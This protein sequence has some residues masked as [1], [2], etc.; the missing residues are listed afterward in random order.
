MIRFIETKKELA[1]FILCILMILYF[2]YGKPA[3]EP[4]AG[5]LRTILGKMAIFSIVIYLFLYAN[6]ILAILSLLLA[7]QLISRS[8]MNTQIKAMQDF[9]PSEQEKMGQ[10]TALNQ[11]PYTLEQEVVKKMAPIVQSSNALKPATFKPLME[12]PE[13]VG[14][15]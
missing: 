14:K 11:F 1:E 5:F 2:I 9:I 4:L 3:P 13:N 8:G 6:P 7:F 15:I 12:G 10:F